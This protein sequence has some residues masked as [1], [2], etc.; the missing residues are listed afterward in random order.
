MQSVDAAL[1][2]VPFKPE[3]APLP[4]TDVLAVQGSF[5]FG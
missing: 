4:T 2:L 1:Y 3:M 5:R